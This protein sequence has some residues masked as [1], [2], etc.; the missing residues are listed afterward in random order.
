MTKITLEIDGRVCSMELPYD[1]ATGTELI[2][3]FCS[4]MHSQTFLVC[5]ILDSLNEAAEEYVED[6]NMRNEPAYIQEN[7]EASVRGVIYHQ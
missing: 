4:L 1:D 6:L 5:T 2:K 7:P 3:A